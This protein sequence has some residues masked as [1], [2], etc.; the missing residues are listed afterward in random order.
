MVGIFPHAKIGKN[1]EWVA[2]HETIAD[3]VVRLVFGC[4]F[5]QP[6]R[7]YRYVAFRCQAGER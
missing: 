5:F 7:R 3:A 4:R 1:L 6:R 2:V